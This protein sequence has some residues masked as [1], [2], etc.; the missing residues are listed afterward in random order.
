[1]V[2]S[3][4]EKSKD[5][6]SNE[7]LFIEGKDYIDNALDIILVVSRSGKILYGNKKAIETYGYSF[8]E[9]VNLNIFTLR[10][11]DSR[12][13]TQ[14]QLN[15]A[16]DRGIKFKSYH[17]KKDGTRFPVEVRSVYSNKKSRD[18][19]VSIIRDISDMEELFKDSKIFSISLDILDDPFVVF[20]KDMNISRWSKGQR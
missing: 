6:L 18:M 16:L 5:I 9:L 2:N 4:L 20:D 14:D 17:Y 1:M 10:N 7:K 8:D 11:E 19:A 12:E 3:V 13:F 15:R